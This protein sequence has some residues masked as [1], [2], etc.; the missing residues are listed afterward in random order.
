MAATMLIALTAVLGGQYTMRK[1]KR[2][3]SGTSVQMLDKRIY[4]YTSGARLMGRSYIYILCPFCGT[5]VRAYIWSLAGS[6]KK[7]LCGAKHT[8]LGGYSI[9]ETDVKKTKREIEDVIVQVSERESQGGSR[10]PG[11]TYEEGINAALRWAIG[12]TEDHP[13]PD[14]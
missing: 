12:E 8:Q 4:T 7:C 2:E 10:F 13:Y 6:G 1:T 11:M 14:A 3:N 5:R 9:K